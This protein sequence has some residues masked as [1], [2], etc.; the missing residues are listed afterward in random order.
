ML[1]PAYLTV[2]FLLLPLAPSFKPLYN[3]SFITNRPPTHLYTSNDIPPA[4]PPTEPSTEPPTEPPT[5]PTAT[6]EYIPV[7]ITKLTKPEEYTSFL[8]SNPDSLVVMKFF[9]PWCRA[10][11]GLSPKFT[12]ISIDPSNAGVIFAQ[13]DVQHNKDFVKSLGILAL[14]NIHFYAGEEGMTEN[15]PCGPTKVPILRTK[16]D[17]YVN[18][19]LDPVTGKCCSVSAEGNGVSVTKESVPCKER[20]GEGAEMTPS[21][22]KTTRN[23]T[24]FRDMPSVDFDAM[25]AKFVLSSYDPG[26]VI[27]LQ[28]NPNGKT[29]YVVA[30]G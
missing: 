26:S 28:G 11:K 17:Q 4:I 5:E 12:K 9:A 30:S 15:F 18:G 21:L 8:A 3:P 23:I 25:C 22:L 6:E 7:P 1:F 10:C 27:M 2:L 14:P 20:V 19:R 29:F 16:L 13:F 24:Y